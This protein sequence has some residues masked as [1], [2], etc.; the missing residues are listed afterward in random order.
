[1]PVLPLVLGVFCHLTGALRHTGR[2]GGAWWWVSRRLGLGSSL[3]S[4]FGGHV[5]VAS[6]NVTMRIALA[7]VLVL[8]CFLNHDIDRSAV[9]LFPAPC[10]GAGRLYPHHLEVATWLYICSVTT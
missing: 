2:G 8:A 1:M 5:V 10:M 9:A 4:L 6:C 3:V 7:M